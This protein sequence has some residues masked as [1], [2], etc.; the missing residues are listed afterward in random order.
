[1]PINKDFKRLVRRRMGKTGESYTAARA[2]VLQ[3]G[4]SAKPAS[5]TTTAASGKKRP[6]ARPGVDYAKS[7]SDEAEASRPRR[8]QLYIRPR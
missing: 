1:M 3:S 4:S 8:A 6:A 5:S 7:V 2:Q